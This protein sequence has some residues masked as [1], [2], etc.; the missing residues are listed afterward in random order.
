MQVALLAWQ[1]RGMFYG[2]R[3]LLHLGAMVPANVK[4]KSTPLLQ[5]HTA[6]DMHYMETVSQLG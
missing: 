3:A 6:T 4:T 1:S 5:L 2:T